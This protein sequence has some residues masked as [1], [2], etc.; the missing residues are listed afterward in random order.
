MMTA[1]TTPSR[2]SHTVVDPIVNAGRVGLLP[3]G[4]ARATRDDDP[5]QQ[6]PVDVVAHPARDLLEFSGA[7][8]DLDHAPRQVLEQRHRIGQLIRRR[9]LM[10]EEVVGIEPRSQRAGRCSLD[11]R[12]VVL[13]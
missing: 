5:L 2:G 11:D 6:V 12:F 13:L 10:A 9:R 1:S 4:G 7:R 3:L 8:E